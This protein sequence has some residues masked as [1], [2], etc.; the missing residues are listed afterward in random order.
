[1]SQLCPSCGHETTGRFCSQCGAA[2]GDAACRECGN[3]IPVG[4]RFCNQCGAPV[5][6]QPTPAMA[7]AAP[8]RSESRLPWVVAG[9]AV[10]ALSGVLLYPKLSE[11]TPPPPPIPA[12]GSASGAALSGGDP[13]NVDLS[14]M[15]PR[16]A[17]DRLFNRVMQNVS[18]GDSA[19]AKQ[20]LPMALQAYGRVPDLDVDG[21]YHLGVL[22]LVGAD[23]E[24][25]LEEANTILSREPGHLFGLFIAAQAED[26]LGK[27]DAARARY[28]EFV[29]GY[30]A[31]MAKQRPEYQEHAQA[32]PPM[33]DA[34]VEGGK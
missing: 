11:T 6:A 16:E 28:Q 2:A 7:A 22:K 33:R 13:R 14:S 20:F 24:G 26:A 32:L 1:M 25:A 3:Q 12:E 21:H 10:L 29:T 4:G 5:A 30:A 19:Q 15:T 8:A 9:V 34:A 31:E 17:A 23:A 27:R 18:A